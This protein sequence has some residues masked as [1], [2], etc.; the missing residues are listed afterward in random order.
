MTT[1]IRIAEPEDAGRVRETYVTWDYARPIAP[2]DT[3]WL[4]EDAGNVVGIVRIAR[5]FG[6]LVLRGMRIAPGWQRRGIGRRMLTS[7]D[8]WLGERECYCIP[9]AH[10]GKFYGQIGFEIIEVDSAPRFLRDRIDEYRRA[11]LEVMVMV[12]NKPGAAASV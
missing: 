3:I 11:S 12:R 5:E 10:L 4:A 1:S 7:L 9:Y 2:D 8:A 6:T